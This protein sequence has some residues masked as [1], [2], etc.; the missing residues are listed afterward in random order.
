[1]SFHQSKPQSFADD[2]FGLP[3]VIDKPRQQEKAVVIRAD[4][5]PRSS[6]RN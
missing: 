6:T 4:L 1:M 3:S 5:R 2:T